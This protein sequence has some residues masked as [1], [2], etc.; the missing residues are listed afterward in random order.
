ME[1]LADLRGKV[2]AINQPDSHSGS[3]ALRALIAPLGRDGRFFG[4]VEVG[5]S[6]AASL[7]MV[8]A[9]AADV[10][11]I[12]CVSH[13][14]LA[15]H[16]PAALAGTGVL[17]RTAAAPALP[18]VTRADAGADLIERLR[19]ALPAPA[20]S[21]RSPPRA[22]PCCWTASRSCRCGLPTDW[23]LRPPRRPPR[24]PGRRAAV[25]AEVGGAVV[26]PWEAWAI[27]AQRGT[28]GRPAA[29]PGLPG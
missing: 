8:A 9:G 25:C 28:R 13:A 26:V 27:S 23:C 24:L 14:L 3:N 22:T 2:A 21:R 16:R 20:P 6:H 18:F 29:W 4:R 19:A 7:A 12:D 15:R 11:A 1:G 17:C 5:G 10:A